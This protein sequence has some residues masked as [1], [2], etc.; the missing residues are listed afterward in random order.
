MSWNYDK[1]TKFLNKSRGSEKPVDGMN[2][3]DVT[4]ERE[5]LNRSDDDEV[6]L[7]ELEIEKEKIGLKGTLIKVWVFIMAVLAIVAI[8]ILMKDKENPD[9]P[10]YLLLLIDFNV[11]LWPVLFINKKTGK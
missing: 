10:G 11:A 7:R 4:K 6:R 2:I 5:T 3:N 9:S 8:E 1:F